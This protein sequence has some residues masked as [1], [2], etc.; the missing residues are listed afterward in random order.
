MRKL[1]ETPVYYVY[2]HYKPGESEIPFYIGKGKAKR[3][4]YKNKRNSVW[5]RIVKKYGGFEAGILHDNLDEYDAFGLEILYIWAFGRLGG[6]GTGVLANLTEGGDGPS[7]PEH[8]A[9]MMGRGNPNYGKK[10]TATATLANSLAHTGQIPWNKNKKRPPF[11]QEWRDKISRAHTGKIVS[12]ETR[13]RMSA[14][15]RGRP[16]SEEHRRKLRKMVN[17]PTGTF[18][19]ASSAATALGVPIHIIRWR[20]QHERHGF[21]YITT[22]NTNVS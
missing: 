16:K 1:D 4:F 17:T 9:R 3:L 13:K 5:N 20:C 19:C 7:S 12:E 18:D 8:S 11:S 21:R 6:R 15:N 22:E 10:A 2:A 14:S